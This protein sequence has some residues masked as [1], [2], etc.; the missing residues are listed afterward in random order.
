[1]EKMSKKIRE[2][3]MNHWDPIG[4]KELPEAQGEYDMYIPDIMTLLSERASPEKI[5]QYLL[6]V[7]Q[8]RMGLTRL[9]SERITN[10]TNELI[11]LKSHD[12]NH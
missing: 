10:T 2:I 5:S 3:L 9:D 6:W 7:E 4:V 8:A 1:M 12:S 11:K